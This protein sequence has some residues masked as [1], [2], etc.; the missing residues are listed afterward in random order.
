M[1]DRAQLMT[2][3]FEAGDDWRDVLGPEAA[4]DAV[5]D[6]IAG[7]DRGEVRVAEVVEIGRAHV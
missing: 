7:L 4:H 1:D 5:R 6:V 2:R 3:L